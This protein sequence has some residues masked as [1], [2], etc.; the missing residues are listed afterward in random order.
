[1]NQINLIFRFSWRWLVIGVMTTTGLGA[2]IA[3]ALSAAAIDPEATKILQSMSTYLAGTKTFSVNAD[4]NWEIVTKNGQKLQL[5]SFATVVVQRPG[6]FFIHR[7][8]LIADAQF[9][10]NGKTLT[11]YG[12]K[13]NVYAQIDAPGSIDSAIRTFEQRAG[14][15]VPGADLLFANP[16]AILSTGVESSAYLGMAY[17]DGIQCHHLAFREDE[18]DWQLW[19][20]TGKKPLPMKYVIT[21]KWQAA[22]PQYEIRLRDWV[23]NPQIQANQFNFVAPPGS[24]KLQALPASELDEFTS[25]MEEQR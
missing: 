18:V 9:I 3:P 20:Q 16:Y 11:L 17:V 24:R 10:F 15:P 19:V 7:Q 14:F 13:E 21:S 5:S 23:I 1:M 4:I 6:S 8:G 12:K 22:A 2:A 25:T